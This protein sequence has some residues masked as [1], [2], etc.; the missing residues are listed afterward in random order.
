MLL[1]DIYEIRLLLCDHTRTRVHLSAYG[2]TR[3]DTREIG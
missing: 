3:V 1:K 2:A